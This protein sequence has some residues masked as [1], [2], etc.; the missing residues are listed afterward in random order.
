MENCY[1]VVGRPNTPRKFKLLL[2]NLE[3][4]RNNTECTII[5]SVNHFPNGIENWKGE[6]YDY[7]IYSDINEILSQPFT[8]YLFKTDEWEWHTDGI[9]VDFGRAVNNLYLRGAQ[10]A[11]SLGKDNFIF[12]NYDVAVRTKQ[13]T[14]YL[15]SSK[16]NLFFEQMENTVTGEDFLQTWFFKLNIDSL[17]MLEYLSTQKGYDDFKF[18]N[19]KKIGFYELIVRRYL[20]KKYKNIEEECE[21]IQLMDLPKLG[22]DMDCDNYFPEEGFRIAVDPKH[23]QIVILIEFMHSSVDRIVS[24]E[25]QGKVFTFGNV[26]EKWYT[27][28]LGEYKEG[29]EYTAIID[30]IRYKIPIKKE[31]LEKN[32]LTYKN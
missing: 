6:L 24:L 19:D 8:N 10:L 29:M 5:L 26:K 12:L 16:K 4:L 32:R 27:M 1:I 22:L 15:E 28:L 18:K 21:I 31:Y 17:D 25:F 3:I 2:H 13:T 20:D 30:G 9:D 23:G 11:K 14:L 7:I